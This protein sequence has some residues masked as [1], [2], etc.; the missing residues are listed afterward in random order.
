MH[1]N[2]YHIESSDTPYL[3]I[4]TF[5]STQVLVKNCGFVLR[6][7]CLLKYISN[8]EIIV[9]CIS[10]FMMLS[11]FTH[12]KCN[13]NNILHNTEVEHCRNEQ[14]CRRQ[15]AK[16]RVCMPRY[17]QSSGYYCVQINILGEGTSSDT[18]FSCMFPVMYSC[19]SYEYIKTCNYH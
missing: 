13:R 19:L 14:T 5:Y 11:N 2:G 1:S 18:A 17:D 9:F 3:Q 10:S 15:H 6:S 7:M 8:K 16:M 12:N 4:N